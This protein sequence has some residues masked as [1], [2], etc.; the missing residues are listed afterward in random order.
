[1]TRPILILLFAWSRTEPEL[2]TY[3]Q[4]FWF[5]GASS[6]DIQTLLDHYPADP[7]AGSPFDTGEEDAY[8]PEYKRIAAIT[9]DFFFHAPRRQV[10]DKF[11][12]TQPA[13]NFC[14]LC[15]SF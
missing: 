13:Y 9:G 15:T 4:T 12:L 11:S 8:T 1:M 3:L 5:P 10:L 6:T 14:A 7:A 2:V